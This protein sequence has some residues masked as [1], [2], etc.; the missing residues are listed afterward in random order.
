[1]SETLK[2]LEAIG[3]QKIY[4]DTHIPIEQISAIL[5]EDY[6]SLTRVQYQGF[7]SILEREYGV[8]L[9]ESKAAALEYFNDNVTTAPISDDTIFTVSTKPKNLKIL[10]IAFIIIVF[11]IAFFYFSSSSK[12]NVSPEY[13]E[14]MQESVVQQPMEDENL[15]D[16]VTD[17]NESNESIV[18]ENATL[19]GE[20]KLEVQKLEPI[21]LEPIEIL[22]H[23][24]VWLGYIDVATNKKQ[25]KTFSDE[26]DLDGN[27]EWLMIF[28]HGYVS[29]VI[30]GKEHKFSDKNTLRLHYKNGLLE[31]IT[32]NE[33]RRLNRGRKW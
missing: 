21:V 33:F 27:A 25:Q 9:S 19:L 23:S 29:I 24:K 22:P 17:L 8:D 26:F 2:K 7:I 5:H 30:N 3:A 16:I 15:S 10:Y 4:E 32:A 11:L 12:E 13:N 31:Q 28:G 1:M 14:L 6:S 18:E 20:Q